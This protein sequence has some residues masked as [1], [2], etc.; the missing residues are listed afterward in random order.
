[1][2]AVKRIRRYRT[3]VQC[4]DCGKDFLRASNTRFCSALCRLVSKV[5]AEGDCWIWQASTDRNGYGSFRLDGR[6]IG[7]HRASYLLHRG[8]IPPGLELDHLCRTPACVNAWHLEPVTP[9]ENFLRG[10]SPTA[11]YV[12]T[13]A[14]K[15]GHEFNEQNTHID[16]EGKKKCRPCAAAYARTRKARTRSE[17]A[18]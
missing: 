8:E 13:G 3:L 16:R 10:E 17:V 6:L 14:C 2:S 9:Q 15:R 5:A 1:M 4:A 7:A 18:A 12:R 11:T